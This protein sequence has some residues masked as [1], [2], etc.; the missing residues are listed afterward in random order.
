MRATLSTVLTTTVVC[1]FASL[2]SAQGITSGPY[3]QNVSRNAIVVVWEQDAEATLTLRYGLDDTLTESVTPEPAMRHEVEL[4]GLEAGAMYQYALFDGDTQ[5]SDSRTFPTAVEPGTPFRFI[6]FGDSRSRPDAHA[7]VI[8]AMAAEDDVRFYIQTGELVA[9]GEV[10]EQWEEYFDIEYPMMSEKPCFAVIGN[11]EE[12]EGRADLFV[13][14]M[15]NPG[16]ASGSGREEYYSFEYG[17]AHF[18]VLDGHTENMLTWIDCIAEYDL[19][20]D[21]CF[22]PEQQAWMEAD[23]EAAAV[24]PDIDH[25]IVLMHIGPYSSKDGRSGSAHMRYLLPYFEELGVSLILTGHD[26]YYERGVS[27]NGI[28]YV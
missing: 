23:L 17:N 4:T 20:L 26:H 21:G 8:D 7:S 12:H 13:A 22:T 10:Q 6:A 11:H 24:D 1:A 14:E 25:L 2:A 19:W 5:V 27:H 3:L 9:D 18:T 28:P 16:E 15:V